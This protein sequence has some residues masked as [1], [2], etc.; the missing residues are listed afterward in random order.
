[1]S[2]ETYAAIEQAR[3]KAGLSRSEFFQVA[4]LRYAK[5]ISQDQVTA[6]LNSYVQQF[7]DDSLD[8]LWDRRA[9]LSLEAVDW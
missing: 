3:A 9:K 5:A 2:T 1:M 6:A 7:G 8:E 4:G